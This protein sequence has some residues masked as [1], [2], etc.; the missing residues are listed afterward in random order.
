MRIDNI[1]EKLQEILDLLRTG[2]A[3]DAFGMT[4][5][6]EWCQYKTNRACYLLSKILDN[7][8]ND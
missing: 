6:L 4:T 1:S 8:N 2:S 5:E 3:P 7:E